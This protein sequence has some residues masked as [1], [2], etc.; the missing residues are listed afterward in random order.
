MLLHIATTNPGKLRDFRHAAEQSGNTAIQ[1]EPLPNL[2]TIAPPEETGTTF[3]AN[4]RLKANFYS[5]Q[6]PNA[7]VLADDSGL[8]ITALQ[9]R[10]GVRSARFAHD[11]GMADPTR[12][13]DENNNAALLLATL[14]E[15]D[16]TCRYRCVLALARDGVV[17]HVAEGTCE[18]QLLADPE[19]TGGFGY[20]PLVL[21]PRYNRTMA[22]LTPDERQ[23]VSHRAHAL[24]NLIEQI[25]AEAT[26]RL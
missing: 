6:T 17:H 14:E 20:D 13:T 12:S 19:G 21:I 10:P 25:R 7:W 3:E 26:H 9:N 22:Q 11:L 8:E 16:R 15:T 23:A 2:S 5:H 24:R 18:G 1:F 4:A